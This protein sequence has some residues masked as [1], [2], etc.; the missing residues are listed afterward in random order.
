MGNSAAS[1]LTTGY[2]SLSG[3]TTLGA[4]GGAE[5]QTLTIA[6]MPS[7]NHANTLTDPGHSHTYQAWTQSIAVAG[8]GGSAATTPQ[9]QNTG[10]VTTGITI[11]NAFTGGGSAHTIVQ[12]TMVMSI[13]VKL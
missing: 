1:R 6:Q 13:Y 8:G 2:F 4:V 5:S 7:H 10:S 9:G 12:P 3:G 11:T